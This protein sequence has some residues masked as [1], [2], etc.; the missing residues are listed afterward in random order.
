MII[1]KD[2]F[3]QLGADPAA[4]RVSQLSRLPQCVRGTGGKEQKLLYLNPNPQNIALQQMP[5]RETRRFI[6]FRMEEARRQIG[7]DTEPF[8]E[9]TITAGGTYGY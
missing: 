7:E 6:E 3:T 9:I 2:I 1:L 5:L 4:M 8:P